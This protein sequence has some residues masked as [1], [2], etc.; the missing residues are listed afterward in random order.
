MAPG[1]YPWEDHLKGAS[2]GHSIRLLQNIRL[3]FKGLPVAKHSCLLG[4][5]ISYKEKQLF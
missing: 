3:G 2:H 5:F 4:T 1:A